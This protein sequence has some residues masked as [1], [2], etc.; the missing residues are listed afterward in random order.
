[1]KVINMFGAPGTGK[2]VM[3]AE[4]F[5]EMKKRGLNVELVTEYAKQ[6]AWDGSHSI[7]QDQLYLF[8]KQNRR[9]DRLRAHVDYVISD[10]PLLLGLVYAPTNYY[11]Q[12]EPMVREVWNSYDN[13]CIFL[14]REYQ[15]QTL[16]RVHTEEEARAIEQQIPTILHQYGMPYMQVEGK[17]DVQKIVDSITMRD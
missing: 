10:S 17:R 9:L 6:I 15:F 1:M 5:A 11:K 4:V 8:A 7:L 12:F 2:S 13:R 16:G 3:A 14:K